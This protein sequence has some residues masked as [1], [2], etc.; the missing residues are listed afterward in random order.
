MEKRIIR[1]RELFESYESKWLAPYA[2][3]SSASKGRMYNEPEHPLR[4][5]YQRDRDRIIHSTAFRR[6]QYKTQV[7][8]NHEGDYFRTR[9]THTLEVAQIGRTIARSLGL[10][11]DLVESISLAHDLG[12]TPFGHAGEYVLDELMED[13]GGFEHNAHGLRVVEVLEKRYPEFPGLNLTLEVR[14]GISKHR[15]L[16]SSNTVNKKINQTTLESQVVDAADEIAYNNH[17]LDDGLKSG[18]LT[19]EQ[20]RELE[21]WNN[22]EKKVMQKYPGLSSSIL[23]IS[24]IKALINYQVTDLIE[25]S[26]EN[27]ESAGIDSFDEALAYPDSLICL[28]SKVQSETKELKAMLKKLLYKNRR[29]LRMTDNASMVIRE[30][31]Q[32]YMDHEEQIPFSTDESASY[33]RKVCDYIAGMTDRY[34][35]EDYQQIFMPPRKY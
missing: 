5:C 28:S 18:I 27:I 4:T 14:D 1:N 34:A 23:N 24:M 9:L 19:L 13:H 32:Y 35:Y 31:F 11:E 20:V 16:Y 25:T 17:D 21:L 7:F 26:K 30:L 8:V 2:M 15:D 29:V 3:K 12:H 10:N 22:I 6:L 33:E